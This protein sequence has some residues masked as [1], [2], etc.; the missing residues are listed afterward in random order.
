MLVQVVGGGNLGAAGEVLA[1]GGVALEAN[2][3]HQHI[4]LHPGA[5]IQ[6]H[7]ALVHANDGSRPGAELPHM[8]GDEPDV[9]HGDGV[10]SWLDL[11][12]PAGGRRSVGGLVEPVPP[13]HLGGIGLHVVLEVLIPVVNEVLVIDDLGAHSPNTAGDDQ[14]LCSTCLQG[15]SRCLNRKGPHAVH[16]HPLAPPG[17][18][19]RGGITD[20]RHHLHVGALHSGDRE[21]A[22]DPHAVIDSHDN[23]A[24]GEAGGAPSRSGDVDHVA[25]T[26]LLGHAGDRGAQLDLVTEPRSQ[27]AQISQ[28]LR[29]GAVVTVGDVN[30]LS[31]Q[32][33]EAVGPF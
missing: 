7:A 15:G 10:A 21:G 20:A 31:Q 2:A 14:H 29:S 19:G 6:E 9:G 30:A 23:P 22:W 26:L 8:V 12:G 28:H 13:L 4:A 17:R 18:Q 24:G 1:E 11:A 16:H 25:T 33:L 3:R 32:L 5:V 27:L